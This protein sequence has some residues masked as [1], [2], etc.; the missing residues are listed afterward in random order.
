LVDFASDIVTVD[1][2]GELCGRMLLS[3]F[4]LFVD[5][6]SILHLLSI[7]SGY[8]PTKIP[9]AKN[10]PTLSYSTKSLPNPHNKERP[11]CP[12]KGPCACSQT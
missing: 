6:S 11:T 1:E 12:T 10:L 7:F 8:E 3:K 9:H 2:G 5:T 4:A